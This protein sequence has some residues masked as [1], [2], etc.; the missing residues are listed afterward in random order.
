MSQKDDSESDIWDYKPLGKRKKRRDSPSTPSTKT[1]RRCTV[2]KTSKKETLVCV[3]SPGRGRGCITGG[4][5]SADVQSLPP[6][7]PPAHGN[8][9]TTSDGS[10]SGDFCPICQMPFS[11]LLGQSQRWHVAECLDSPRDTC[12]GTDIQM[13][14]THLV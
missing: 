3:K 13:F 14:F 7:S 8:T 6:V 1:K 9:D 12:E 2:K 5:S 10:S 4:H 11:I